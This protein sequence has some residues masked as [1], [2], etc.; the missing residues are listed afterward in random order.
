MSL[1]LSTDGNG[2]FE[3]LAKGIYHGTCYKI[4]DLGTTEQ[5]YQDK[6]TKRKRIQ[7]GFEITEAVDPDDNKIQMEDERPF[8]VFRVYTASLFEAAALRKDLESWRGKSF[9][10]EE[11]SGFDISKLLG[12][13][14]RIEVG[15]TKATEFGTGGNPKILSLQRPDGGVSK[16]ETVNELVKFDLDLYCD[17]WRGNMTDETKAMVDVFDALPDWQ[18][19]EI[20]ESFELIAAKEDGAK[21]TETKTQSN[22][23]ED[24][25][26]E[27]DDLEDNIPF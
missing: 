24:L 10:E 2:E 1:T 9:T 23:L 17:E 19:K 20:E 21:T 22:G 26:P 18:Q 25:K 8:A 14:A 27:D 3:K 16:V 4:V 15:H 13:T 6:K 5:E 7:L 12:C 11:L